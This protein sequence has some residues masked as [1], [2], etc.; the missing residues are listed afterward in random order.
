VHY[1]GTI[2][3]AGVAAEKITLASDE[4]FVMGDYPSGSEDSR[5]ANIGNVKSEYIIGKAW[6]KL[7]PF[8]DAGFIN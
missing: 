2:A 6:F 3:D 4:C 1:T 8:D 7:L 5:Y